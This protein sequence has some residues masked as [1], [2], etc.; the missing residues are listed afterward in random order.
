MPEENPTYVP[1][2]EVL[3]YEELLRF[4]RVAVGLGIDKI[5]LTGGEPLVR[6]D[7]DILVAG[8]LGIPGVR[9][10]A[11]TTNGILLAEQAERLYAAGLRRLNVHLDT[12]DAARFRQISR[13]DGLDR[14]L[15]GL[16]R[17]AELGFGPIAERGG[18]EGHRQA[19]TVPL[20]ASPGHNRPTWVH[21][22]GRRRV[23]AALPAEIAVR[24]REVAPLAWR[25]AGSA[26]RVRFLR[27]GGGASSH[28]GA[29]LATPAT[30]S[31]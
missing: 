9:D 19:D 5:R 6:R 12:L 15:A 25:P 10:L 13:R 31:A 7:L 29:S 1:K 18:R 28:G 24:G 21:A 2:S 4:T 27:H 23:A 26:A 11:L 20:D 22:A 16:D 8:L 17:A 14:V 30:A 3:S